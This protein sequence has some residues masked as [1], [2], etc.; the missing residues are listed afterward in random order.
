MGCSSV[1][2][3]RPLTSTYHLIPRNNKHPPMVRETAPGIA[4]SSRFVIRGASN[5]MCARFSPV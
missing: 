3:Y 1:A 4:L 5:I 2:K